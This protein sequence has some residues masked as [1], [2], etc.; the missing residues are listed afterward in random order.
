[1]RVWLFQIGQRFDPSRT[2]ESTYDNLLEE[3]NLAESLGFAGVWAAEHHFSNYAAFPNPLVYLAGLARET[4]RIRL[5]TMAVVLPMHN[6]VRVAEEAAMVD[7]LSGGRLELGLARGYTPFEYASL[8]MD[9]A[10]SQTLM[11]EGV[12]VIQK[13]WR[14][15]EVAHEGA[16]WS[17]D[18]LSLVPRT[19]QRPAPPLWYACGS[20]ATI[21]RAVDQRMNVI[22]SL[23]IKDMSFV[24]AFSAALRETTEAAGVAA[25]EI[26]YGVQVPA[27]FT[28][29]AAT[30]ARVGEQL[31]W[32]YK[33]AGSFGTGNQVRRNGFVVETGE[34]PG[35]D[36]SVESMTSANLVGDA[37]HIRGI[38]AE[39][40]SL[41]VTDLSLNFEFGDV[42]APERR[43]AMVAL[44]EVLGLDARIPA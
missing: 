15:D 42:T 17:F 30:K 4:S 11:D 7:Q 8:G 20:P 31:R 28:E 5:G 35:T 2:I 13:L 36:G 6:P 16:H 21:R 18:R 33:L 43:D 29:S 25:D 26:R 41:G 38:V 39:F 19:R 44:A 3:A 23:G 27:F 10:D 9:F 1:M 12:E 32:M 37:E 24:H 34:V 14:N 22:Q 40:E